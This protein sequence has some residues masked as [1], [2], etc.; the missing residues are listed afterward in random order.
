MAYRYFSIAA[1]AER[2]LQRHALGTGLKN[3]S[4]EVIDCFRLAYLL[5]EGPKMYMSYAIMH[6]QIIFKGIWSS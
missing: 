3:Y 6:V 4:V 5:F 2:L 1:Q